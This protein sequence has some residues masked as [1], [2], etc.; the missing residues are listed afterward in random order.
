LLASIRIRRI[1][2]R[3]FKSITTW[4]LGGKFAPTQGL[5]QALP[6]GP[7]VKLISANEH[8]PE[9]EQCMCPLKE[10]VRLPRHSLPHTKLPPIMLANMML[11][12]TTLLNYFPP[13]S[14]ISDTIS[15]RTLL[16]GST[17]NYKKDFFLPFGSYRQVHEDAASRNSMIACTKAAI[18][19]GPTH[20][21]QGGH[22]FMALD[23]GRVITGYSWTQIP[24]PQLV[25]DSSSHQVSK[26]SSL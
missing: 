7:R 4:A 20:N 9:A 19:L 24:L 13:K 26:V 5:L 6:H 18:Y 11:H 2:C 22:H 25:L 15:P 8:V 17:L 3:C 23:T 12:C 1:D 14:S 16:T 10:R 21:L